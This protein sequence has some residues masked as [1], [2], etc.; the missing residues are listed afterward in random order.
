MKGLIVEREEARVAL[1]EAALE[2]ALCRARHSA[3][4][5]RFHQL[6]RELAETRKTIL[7]PKKAEKRACKKAKEETVSDLVQSLEAMNPAERA[8]LIDMMEQKKENRN[9]KTN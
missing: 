4:K 3:A 8:A 6:D 7:P 2:L 1:K 9:E 5:N